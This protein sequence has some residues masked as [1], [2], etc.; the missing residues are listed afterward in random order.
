MDVVLVQEI[1]EG[2]GPSDRRC[3]SGRL[4]SAETLDVDGDGRED[5]LE[6]GLVL[7]S[8]A[9]A[10]HAVAVGELVD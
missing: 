9:A 1:L 8:V 2:G 7:A 10:A 6:V 4:Q 3:S 5:V